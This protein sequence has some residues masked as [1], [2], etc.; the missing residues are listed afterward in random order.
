M[1]APIRCPLLI[2]T[3]LCL[4]ASALAELP[5][6]KDPQWTPVRD[7]VY[8]Q[9]VEGRL[10]TKEPL[11]AAAVFGN[12]LYVGTQHGVQQ[13]QGDALVPAGGPE[14][15]LGRLRMRNGAL[16]AFSE[17]GLW[18]FGEERW[19]KLAEDSFVISP[20]MCGQPVARINC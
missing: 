5:M 2:L 19:K 13:L 17:N 4:A 9:E 16:Y 12:V 11:L 14:G 15:A 7:D 6:P 20:S 3:A 10:E 18:R 1:K 8:L